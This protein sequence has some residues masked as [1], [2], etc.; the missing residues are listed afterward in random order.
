MIRVR[1][2]SPSF[3]IAALFAVTS[4]PASLACSSEAAPS[5]AAGD[6]PGAVGAVPDPAIGDGGVGP[7][8]LDG[9]SDA[10]SLA[11]GSTSDGSAPSGF[12]LVTDLNAKGAGSSPEPLGV[13]GGALLFAATDEAHGRELF[14]T[15]GTQAGT[16]LVTDLNPGPGSANPTVAADL[17]SRLV[18]AIDR[19]PSSSQLWITDGTAAGTTL[20]F[21]G[22]L[23][24]PR[25]AAVV[26]STFYFCAS[27]PNAGGGL[28]KLWQSDGTANGTVIA[29]NIAPGGGLVSMGGALYFPAY[30]GGTRT[31]YRFDGTSNGA[32][33]TTAAKNVD[34]LA[35]LG[36]ELVFY[37][38]D[39]TGGNEPWVSDGTEA[40]TK[41]LADV[42]PGS[43]NG[44]YT[45]SPAPVVVGGSAYFVA[46]SPT[47]GTELWKTDGTAAGTG[48]VKDIFPGAATS[49]PS[50]LRATNGKLYFSADDGFKGR[51]PWVSDGTAAGTK[52]IADVRSGT[53]SAGTIGPIQ[54]T[55]LGG[56]VYFGASDG[57]HGY[58]LW[59]TD[60]TAA[61][62]TMVVDA[63]AGEGD[64]YP[65]KL[66]VFGN[67][68][69]YACADDGTAAELCLSDGTAAGTGVRVRVASG[70]GDGVLA[71]IVASSAGRV[72]FAGRTAPPA[73]RLAETYGLVTSDGTA[74]GTSIV[75]P[76]AAHMVQGSPDPVT[77][78]GVAFF[79]ARTE[80][81]GLE[82]WKSDGTVAG[83]KLVRDIAAGPS[84]GIDLRAPMAV[85]GSTLYFVASDGAH[86]REL[87]RSDGTE[88]GTVMVGDIGPGDSVSDGIVAANDAVY[89]VSRSFSAAGV[90]RGD[91]SGL[92]LLAA[93]NLATGLAVGA[94]RPLWFQ[95]GAVYTSDGTATNVTKI[96]DVPSGNLVG[97][98]TGTSGGAAFTLRQPSQQSG[99]LWA[100]DLTPT[101][102]IR[103]ATFAPAFNDPFCGSGSLEGIAN[104][105]VIYFCADDGVHGPE[106]W[107][108]DL[109]L[110]GTMLVTDVLPGAIGSKPSRFA[111]ALGRVYFSADDG[112]H[113]DE[114][115]S[116]DGSAQGTKLI[117]DL[118]PGAAGASP[119]RV[120]SMNGKLFFGAT[121]PN[122]G[123]ELWALDPNAAAP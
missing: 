61:G 73:T 51:E 113:G 85:V 15:D 104:G 83:T 90:Y 26:G 92:H 70:T 48:I 38:V 10:A 74:A 91:A 30:V 31:L 72:F 50:S 63:F 116:T 96:F 66:F 55:A 71:P 36:N 14:R 89:F 4:L 5:G 27:S 68:L 20:V 9:A 100:T 44:V 120:T 47:T 93:T 21:D 80:N 102:T 110:A 34:G 111:V 43:A 117:G 19:G 1:P 114:L 17:G 37:G 64:S 58:E 81:E 46:T 33:V 122:V 78:G 18:I 7:S 77:L 84:N 109:T 22:Y 35:V 45:S 121:G 95:G 115:W 123:R 8:A 40:G 24:S 88:L 86:G 65:D 106:L 79:R 49:S 87:W 103:V 59:R 94:N 60:G 62:T 118:V 56:A 41:R 32:A 119:S 6:G 16:S 105:N 99:E 29:A 82:L 67:R 23:C 53:E 101:G 75:T 97:A 39:S 11:D 76:A 25:R 107:R 69:A 108:S 57:T 3:V 13:L 54:F 52:R 2:A 112:T 42:S 98:I 12:S 28:T